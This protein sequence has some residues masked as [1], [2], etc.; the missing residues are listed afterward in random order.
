MSIGNKA[1][2]IILMTIAGMVGAAACLLALPQSRPQDALLHPA[3]VV[4][5]LVVGGL[6]AVYMVRFPDY[7]RLAL[8]TARR[9]PSP[10]SWPSRR[11][12]APSS[13]T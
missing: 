1:W 7:Y 12:A 8:D 9:R 2:Y 5:L 4:V 10:R 11:P 13:T 3:M 6:G